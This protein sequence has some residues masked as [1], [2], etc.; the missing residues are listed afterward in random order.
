MGCVA[1]ETL[2]L[3]IRR[4]GVF[5]FGGQLGMAI[6]TYRG[7]TIFEKG[8]L[9]RGMGRVASEALALLNRLMHHAL[10]L[11]LGSVGVTGIAQIL[12]FFLQHPLIPSDMGTM[13]R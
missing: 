6:E 12:H 13:A 3:G 9:P 4:M 7:E 5:E 10:G 1:C 11:I 8:V 2:A